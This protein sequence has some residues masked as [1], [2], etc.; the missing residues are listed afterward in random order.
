MPSLNVVSFSVNICGDKLTTL[1]KRLV[2][3][4]GMSCG[5]VV[6]HSYDVHGGKLAF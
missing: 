2:N 3:L 6:N 4:I 5:Q 1:N